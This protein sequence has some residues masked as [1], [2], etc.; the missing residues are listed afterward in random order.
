MGKLKVACF[1]VSIDGFGAGPN[2][3]L[4][5]PLGEGGLQLHEWAFATESFQNTH[6]TGGGTTGTDDDFVK[7]GFENMGA[8]IMGRNMFGPIRGPWPN[9]DWKGWW[10][11]NPPYHTPAFILTN[12]ARAPIEMAGGTTFHF[13][14]EGIEAALALAQEAAG[15][16]DIR[17]GGGVSTIRQYLQAGLIDEIHLVVSPVLLG[18]GEALFTNLDLAALGYRCT[19][20]VP[21]EKAT[22]FLIEKP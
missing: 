11:N 10:G 9:D 6:G 20:R 15:E 13:V 3:S 21:G 5:N 12:H 2:Q 22:H 14:T 1:A 8:W 4:Q 16:L 19:Q 17:L 7:K 18:R